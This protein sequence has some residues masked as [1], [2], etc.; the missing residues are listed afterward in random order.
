M[1]TLSQTLPRTEPVGTESGRVRGVED[2]GVLIFRGIPYAAAPVGELG[3]APPRRHPGWQGVRE[4]VENGPTPTLGPAT[5]NHSVPEVAVPGDERLNLNLFTPTT[6]PGARLPVYVWLHGGGYIGG[7]PGGGWFNGTS[8]AHRGIVTVTI[9][10]RLGLEGFGHVPDAPDNRGVLDQIAALEWVQ[11]N[12]SDFGGDPTQVTLG[13]QSAGAG[14]TLAL[15]ASTATT[16]LFG[17]AISH[18]APLPDITLADAQAVGRALAKARG[19]EH[20]IK[21][22]SALS[23][24]EVVEAE[25]A[26]QGTSVWS[27]LRSLNRALRERDPVTWFG[28]VLGAPPFGTDILTD[29][30]NTDRPLLLG[31]TSHEFNKLVANVNQGMSR[32]LTPVVLSSFGMPA[33]RARAYPAAYPGLSGIELVGQAITDRAFRYPV[34]RIGAARAR[35]GAP[36]WAWDFRWRSPVNGQAG[37]CLDLP[38]AWNTL[39]AERVARSAGSD[40]PQALAEEMHGAIVSFIRTGDPGWPV[41]TPAKPVARV[42]DTPS[43]TGRDPYRFERIAVEIGRGD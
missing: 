21:G 1:N 27:G 20:S 26:L 18:S 25:R 39:D 32:G 2:D 19:V 37:H 34:A 40:P 31:A 41:Y 23:R 12:I 36:T 11:R 8:F 30:A 15:L 17:R 10:Y 29:L 13:G 6:D 35:T 5:V 16:G 28:P 14:S 9:T 38:F 33:A 24:A 43:W 3:F 4:A 22:W 42:F 7:A